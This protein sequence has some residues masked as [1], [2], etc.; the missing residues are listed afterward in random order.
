MIN[1]R[2]H[3]L[4]AAAS[5]LRRLNIDEEQPVDVFDAVR[6][7]G[8]WL[9]FHRLDRL[10]G[11]FVPV[12]TGGVM[13]TTERPPAVQRYTAAHEIGHV[14]MDHSVAL[15]DEEFIFAPTAPERERLAQLFATY[16]VMPP[17]LVF[18]TSASH[19]ISR[20]QVTPAQ[21]YLVARD[22]RV[23][24]EAAVRQLGTWTT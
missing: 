6:R 13:I 12:A 3:A 20:H 9:T 1:R 24:Y 11:T 14:A 18:R 4:E 22:M 16:F 17:A 10:L 15:D 21:A 19:G 2:R 7:L 5:L 8:L 23:S